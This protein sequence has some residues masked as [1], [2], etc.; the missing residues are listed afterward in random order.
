[1]STTD[2]GPLDSACADLVRHLL[3][4]VQHD[5]DFASRFDDGAVDG[6]LSFRYLVAAI[7]EVKATPI[8]QIEQ[9][10]RAMVRAQPR[11]RASER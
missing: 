10:L 7:A 5:S 6:R 11:T 2:V 1:M 8:E 3:A 9:E 4:R